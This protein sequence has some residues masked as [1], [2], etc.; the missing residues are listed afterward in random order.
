MGEAVQRVALHYLAAGARKEAFALAFKV[1][2]DYVAHYRVEYGV[3]QE[4]EPLVVDGL[5]LGVALG[6]AAVH[7]RLLVQADVVG[8]ES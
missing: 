4:F 2:E 3:A 6:H 5:A 8:V 1:A 7:E